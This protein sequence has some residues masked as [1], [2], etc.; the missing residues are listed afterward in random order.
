MKIRPTPLYLHCFHN[1]TLL[2]CIWMPCS[3]RHVASQ[4][5]SKTQVSAMSALSTTLQTNYY[6]GNDLMKSIDILWVYQ[7]T[8]ITLCSSQWKPTVK[9]KIKWNCTYLS[10]TTL[11][12]GSL[13]H[14]TVH[15]PAP[16]LTVQLA[17]SYLSWYG[18]GD[19]SLWWS[20]EMTSSVGVHYFE[21]VIY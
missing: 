17:R 15:V 7:L 9:N 4:I 19:L 10:C 16:S 14:Q 3:L 8:Q 11:L 2:Y 12:Q 21:L 1:C 13:M 18:S 20:V 5:K 6:N